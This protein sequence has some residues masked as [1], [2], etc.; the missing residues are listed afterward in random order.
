MVDAYII[1]RNVVKELREAVAQ[2]DNEKVTTDHLD[3][4]SIKKITDHI[5]IIFWH[6]WLYNS[7]ISF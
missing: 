6:R 5:L 4:W 3:I 1:V 7:I 2:F